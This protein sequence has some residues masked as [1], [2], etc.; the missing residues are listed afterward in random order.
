M[1]EAFGAELAELADLGVDGGEEE[2]RVGDGAVGDVARAVVPCEADARDRLVAPPGL[3]E[4]RGAQSGQEFH[5][6]GDRVRRAVADAP[7]GRA[8]DMVC[9]RENIIIKKTYLHVFNIEY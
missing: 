9:V 6:T 2:A 7:A 1:D 3:V 4:R 8:V 5:Y